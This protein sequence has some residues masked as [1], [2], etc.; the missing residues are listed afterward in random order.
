MG[1]SVPNKLFFSD[2]IEVDLNED[3]GTTHKRYRSQGLL[4]ILSAYNFTIDENDPNDQEVALDPELLG[5]VFENLLASYNPETATTARKATGSYYTPREIVD[6]MV[7]ESLKQYFKTNLQDVADIETKLED[8]FS[9]ATERQSNPFGEADTKRMVALIDDLRIVDPAVGSGAFPMG[10]LNKL[11]FILSKLDTDNKLWKETQLKVVDGV[12]D[13]II[14]QNLKAQITARFAEKNANYGRKLYL[15]QNVIYGVDIQQIAIEIA[16]L[17]FFIALL[18]DEKI[19][20]SKYNWGV[21]SLPNLDFKLMQGNS[22]VSE[23]V[24]INLDAD[25]SQSYG[26]LIRDELDVLVDEFQSR[27]SEFQSEA[28]PKKKSQLKKTVENLIIKIFEGKLKEQKAGYLSQLKSI[29]NK[30]SHFSNASQKTELIAKEVEELNRKSG[31][32]LKAAEKQL[33]DFTTGFVAKPF[34]AWKLYFAEVF[35]EKEG[36]DIV[37]ANPPYIRQENIKEL[38]PELSNHYQCYDS[39]ADIYVYFY[40][41]GKQILKNNGTLTYI[42]SN[43]Y[44][45]SGYGEKLRRF[46]TNNCH[47]CRIIDFG[48]APV[49]EAIAYPSIIIL[50][51]E[52]PD[53]NDAQVFTWAPGPPLEEFAHVVEECSFAVAQEKLTSDGWR[54]ESPSVLRLLEKLRKAGKPLG[55]YVNGR[56]YRGII[57]GLNEAFVVDEATVDRFI[58]EHAP[59]AEL[60]K[61]MLRGRDVKR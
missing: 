2:E 31:F 56:L 45:R 11:V 24:G 59:S 6:Y 35:H 50:K 9:T 48:D 15:I 41:R 12:P 38:K 51:N 37:I 5:K 39:A 19:D 33:R 29:E 8:L 61:P 46:V 47:I 58:K 55:E 34:F 42:S 1:L 10:I 14:K 54:L 13:P 60:L 23:F 36:F 22:L 16:K 40:E 17:R 20:K 43:K 3:Y 26:K 30:Y 7:N 18:V 4:N 44:F 21:E 25:N 53:G 28:D 32:D 57:T 52:P 27:K 49:F